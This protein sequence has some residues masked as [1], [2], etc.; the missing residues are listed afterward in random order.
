MTP[1]SPM[2][3]ICHWTF[4]ISGYFAIPLLSSAGRRALRSLRGGVPPDGLQAVLARRGLSARRPF[5]GLLLDALQAEKS[6]S[7]FFL[8]A[9]TQ[10][11]VLLTC[12]IDSVEFRRTQS[13]G[14]LSKAEFRRPQRPSERP[15]LFEA[16]E[17][18][19]ALDTKCSHASRDKLALK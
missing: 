1:M 12:V 3:R 5:Q 19:A 7:S 13:F 10:H 18:L 14:L 2:V 17:C 16:S 15:L 11:V 6:C 9:M 4:A 8:P